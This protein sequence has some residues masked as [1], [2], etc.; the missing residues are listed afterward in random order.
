MA[1]GMSSASC[2]SR[3]AGQLRPLQHFSSF[4]CTQAC[5]RTEAPIAGCRNRQNPTRGGR[6]VL[7]YIGR[8]TTGSLRLPQS[9]PAP[10]PWMLRQ[11]IQRRTEVHKYQ[12]SGLPVVQAPGADSGG[13]SSVHECITHETCA[14]RVDGS[15]EEAQSPLS[16]HERRSITSD[17]Q[18]E[19]IACQS[20]HASQNPVPD[21]KVLAL[22]P[23]GQKGT[24]PGPPSISGVSPSGATSRDGSGVNESGFWQ[25]TRGAL[26]ESASAAYSALVDNTLISLLTFLRVGQLLAWLTPELKNTYALC[27]GVLHSVPL[28]S[29]LS[30]TESD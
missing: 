24:P 21:V 7:H 9:R 28:L 4:N 25:R 26:S 22:V 27:T 10:Q 12:T 20:A 15:H 3:H 23:P 18:E 5:R 17:S 30:T 14:Q 6:T 19:W 13:G 29:S 8:L 2:Y 11:E 1:L 16:S